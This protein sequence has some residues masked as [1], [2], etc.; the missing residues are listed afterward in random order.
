MEATAPPAAPPPEPKRRRWPAILIA[1]LFALICVLFVAVTIDI[2]GTD[3]CEEA[4][5]QAEQSGAF[6]TDECLDK[7]SANKTATII[8]G[9]LSALA[10]LWTVIVAIGYARG[11]AS[12]RSLAIA[13]G[14]TAVLILI[15]FVL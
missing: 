7:S 14:V 12:G 4:L 11:R 13:A 2:A 9:G 8:A 1:I 10:A 5:E 3:T 6:T 15:T